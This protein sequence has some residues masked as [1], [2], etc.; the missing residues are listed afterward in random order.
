MAHALNLN[1]DARHVEQPGAF[2]SPRLSFREVA[3]AS[4]STS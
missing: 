1:A 4:V 3:R 2:A